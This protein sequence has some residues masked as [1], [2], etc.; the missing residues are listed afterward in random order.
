MQIKVAGFSEDDQANLYMAAH[1]ASGKGR[2]GL[3]IS[4]RVR[5]VAGARWQVRPPTAHGCAAPTLIAVRK[6]LCLAAARARVVL[7]LMGRGACSCQESCL[8]CS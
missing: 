3:G 4:D 7:M 1:G 5:K 2:Q 8:G 6:Q